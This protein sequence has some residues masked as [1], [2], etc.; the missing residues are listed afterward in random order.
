M[1]QELTHD[2][3]S[4]WIDA[5][6]EAIFD[7]VSDVTRTPEISPEIRRC[8][9][10]GGATGPEVGARF[11][12]WNNVGRGP[13]WFNLPVVTV[14][15]RGRTFAIERTEPGCGTIEWRYELRPEDG[16]TRVTESY[17]VKKPIKAFGWFIIG[18]LYRCHDRQADL[19]RG[20]EQ[21]LDRLAEVVGAPVRS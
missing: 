3:V 11:R 9:W 7:V 17:T 2:S 20:M 8:T 6:P 14:V 4:R 19:R 12:A 18:T 13:S 10:V 15:Q 16:G 1:R 21:T 5:T